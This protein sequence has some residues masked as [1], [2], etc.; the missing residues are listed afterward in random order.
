MHEGRSRRP[1]SSFGI[2]I[3]GLDFCSERSGNRAVS[4]LAPFPFQE[5]LASRISHLYETGLVKPLIP[6]GQQPGTTHF[7]HPTLVAATFLLNLIVLTACFAFV[8]RKSMQTG[9]EPVAGL[10]AWNSLVPFVKRGEKG[11]F[12]LAPMVG[13]RSAKDVSTDEA[14]ED[15]TTEGQR[16]RR[17][18][19]FYPAKRFWL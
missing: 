10:R 2:D 5:N 16:T 12:I 8:L 18:P 7:A 15:A 3:T 11:I 13:R 17:G 1:Y 4:R 19:L 6:S 14:S 9:K